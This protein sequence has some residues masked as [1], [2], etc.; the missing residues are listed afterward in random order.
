M[1]IIGK[2]LFDAVRSIFFTIDSV[3]YGF[4][5]I[6]YKLI[7]SLANVD[8]YS[9]NPAI[10][11]LLNRVYIIVGIFMLFKLAFSIL[12]YIVDPSS[13]SDS[14]KGFTGLV[15]RVMIAVLLLVL[16]P[17]LFSKIYEYQGKILDSNILPNLILGTDEK[18]SD[19][20]E[21]AAIDLQFMMFGP[22]FTVNTNSDEL[23]ACASDPN[24]RPLSN[25][26]GSTDMALKD[27]CLE[28]FEEAMSSD[29][30]VKASGVTLDNFFK[31]DGYTRN[32][33]SLG[34]LLTWTDSNGKY[35]VNYMFIVST[36]CGGYLVFLLF[37][38]CFDIASRAI[39]LM[40]LQLLSPVAII[41]SVDP[42]SSS[43][44][45]KLKD[46]G[47]ECFKTF[48]SLFLRL[49]VIYTVIQMIKIVTAKLFADSGSLYYSGFASKADSSLNIWIYIF[50]ILGAFAVA[51]KIPELI[52]KAFGIKMSGE[53]NMNPFKNP[54]VTG[55]VGLGVGA[56]SGLAANA[57]AAPGRIR[58]LQNNWRKGGGFEGAKQ[59][60][61]DSGTNWANKLSGYV[62][63]Q[64]NGDFSADVRAYRSSLKG[65]KWARKANRIAFNE[66]RISRQDY[67]DRDKAYR[68]QISD[69][70]QN[71]SVSKVK[72]VEDRDKARQSVKDARK[73]FTTSAVSMVSPFVDAASTVAGIPV[74]GISAGVRS[75]TGAKGAT[76]FRGVYESIQRGRMAS[77]DARVE[78]DSRADMARQGTYSV[79]DR[80]RDT[81]DK[82]AG[83]R[84]NKTYGVGQ[85]SDQIK[86]LQN[87]ISSIE[88]QRRR[89]NEM[90]MESRPTTINDRVLRNLVDNL[91]RSNFEERGRIIEDINTQLSNLGTSHVDY[92]PVS[93]YAS[94]VSSRDNLDARSIELHKEKKRLEDVTNIGG[95]GGGPGG[96]GGPRS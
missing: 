41:T 7:I 88:Q 61:L 34:S 28:A 10:E 60:F 85:V 11:S 76:N 43:Q 93:T 4:I 37:S 95:P 73:N 6:I 67:E 44:N 42:S 20:L 65:T 22:F 40:F 82:F 63:S 78:R 46:W 75:V 52:E 53:I 24:D 72:M 23:S 96:P 49:V 5:P 47:M 83:V 62:S 84:G 31:A 68:E 30:N 48:I 2:V 55:A 17:F 81:M 13:F 71:I 21:N 74:G 92:G 79:G 15:R 87:E 19:D 70:R 9:N 39:K 8:L 50:L 32:F 36:I 94:N 69:I 29:S 16:V 3:V 26:I 66:G 18:S 56:A 90:I 27:G 1:E 58:E 12:R 33:S 77:N 54:F 89:A 91:E 57:I 45:D 64:L 51:K 80:M 86:S 38:F 14:A 25:V 59:R 35:V